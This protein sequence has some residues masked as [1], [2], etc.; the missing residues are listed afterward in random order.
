VIVLE[1]ANLTNPL[2]LIKQI[3]LVFIQRRDQ[4]VE[5]GIPVKEIMT[6]EPITVDITTKI[7]EA[8]KKMV[9]LD[10]GS[11]IVMEGNTPV[12]ILTERD[13]VRKI[14]SKNASPDSLSMRNVITT[15]LITLD[16][17]E[18][19][20]KAIDLMLKM[21]IRRIP[22]VQDKK[23]VGLVTETDLVS[24]SVEMGNIFFDLIN[25]RKERIVSPDLEIPEIISRGVCESCGK[26]SDN[27]DYFNGS[28]MCEYCRETE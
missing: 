19:I 20:Q 6:R 15:P 5:I 7:S 3:C 12:G 26:Y 13:M 17:D 25:M 22:I 2:Y 11:V 14:I 23:L 28:L 21:H 16:A 10:V 4:A 8:A 18:D 24:V 9:D 1:S 27:L